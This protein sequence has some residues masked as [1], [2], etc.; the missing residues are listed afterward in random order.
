MN[1]NWINNI[2]YQV[3]KSGN[4][5]YLY[6]GLN[7]LLFI[8]AAIAGSIFYLTG[9][10]TVAGSQVITHF[11][12][13]PA[14]ITALPL[15]FYTIITYAFFNDGLF[16]LLFNMLTLY[17]LSII[18]S[19]FLKVHQYH[20]VY[21]FGCIL[22]ALFCLAVYS[23]FPP[24]ISAAPQTF[25]IGS[26]APVMAIT[27]AAATL[28]PDYSIRL[29]LIGEVRLKY[30]VGALVLLNLFVVVSA[31]PA[32]GVAATGGA[33]AGFIY[34]RLLRAGTDLAKIF[35]RK[36]K[37][38]VVHNS[39]Q[40]QAKQQAPRQQEIDAILDKISQSGYENLSK[41]EKEKLFRASKN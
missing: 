6:I 15:R 39:H 32:S 36:P 38:K 16:T 17:W 30:I 8:I 22:G 11:F 29:L 27:A 19:D 25:I 28:V 7:I 26:I 41:E 9:Q 21:L 4:P 12:A 33:F 23:I 5:S 13:L 40:Q 10:A 31:A 2:V 3:F 35:K 24:L 14:D 18:F 37:L 1:K 34:I 20:F